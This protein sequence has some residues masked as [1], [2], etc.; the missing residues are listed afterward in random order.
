[1][2]VIDDSSPTVMPTAITPPLLFDTTYPEAAVNSRDEEP[3]RLIAEVLV[4]LEI[5]EEV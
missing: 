1:M 4:D 3:A 5:P 2:I